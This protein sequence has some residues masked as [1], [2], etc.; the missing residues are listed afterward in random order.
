MA[1]GDESAFTHLF[2]RYSDELFTYSLKILHTE[3]WAEEV[4][5]NMF[6]QLW[7]HREALRGIDNPRS[8]LFR[9]AANRAI[10]ILRANEKAI[11]LRYMQSV[12]TVYT[13][14]SDLIAKDNENI[15]EKA[16][17][18]LPE[19][20][21]LIYQLRNREGMSYEQISEVLHVSKHTV[22]NQL[23]KALE[24]IRTYL[25]SNGIPLLIIAVIFGWL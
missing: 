10:D 25:V 13:P 4:I 20:R 2:Y 23:A 22:R 6:M 5:Q 15:I 19:K 17:H 8:Y 12:S 7:V 18:Q 1:S 11:R 3:F 14:E 24:N 16:I 21:K 9:I